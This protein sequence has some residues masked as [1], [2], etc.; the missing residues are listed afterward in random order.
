MFL[1]RIR[2]VVIVVVTAT[3]LTACGGD[4]DTPQ[5]DLRTAMATVVRNGLS[6][7]VTLSGSALGGLTGT[8]SFALDS[9]VMGIFNGAAGLLQKETISG[10]LTAATQSLPFDTSVT[11]AYDGA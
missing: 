10:T 6:A 3:A 7:Q 2:N 8:G 1:L 5:Y 9:G 11:N 4:G